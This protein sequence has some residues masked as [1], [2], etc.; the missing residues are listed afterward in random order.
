MK[1]LATFALLATSVLAGD[2]GKTCSDEHIDPATEVLTANCDTGDG[3]G[4][5]NSASLDLNTCLG[6]SSNK[7]QWAKQGN[8]GDACEDCFAYRLPDP[9]YGMFGVTR[10]WM[11]CT[12]AGGPA[13]T[14]VNL[15]ST[16]ITNKFGTLACMP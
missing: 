1:F 9:V 2:F 4:T 15:D 6:F 8:F 12:C 14:S 11:N 16:R 5:L 3:K 7:I 13:E 10:V